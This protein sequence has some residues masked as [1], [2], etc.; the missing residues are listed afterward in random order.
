MDMINARAFQS[1]QCRITH[2]FILKALHPHVSIP[3]FDI[4]EHHDDICCSRSSCRWLSWWP[5][6]NSPL[7]TAYVQNT[8]NMVVLVMA[9]GLSGPWTLPALDFKSISSISE[10][11]DAAICLLSFN[12]SHRVWLCKR[13]THP[14]Q[15]TAYIFIFHTFSSIGFCPFFFFNIL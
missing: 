9:K 1:F 2:P 15:V 6:F 4:W 13:Q 8:F 11:T 14:R 3:S 5:P 12:T 7:L 10:I